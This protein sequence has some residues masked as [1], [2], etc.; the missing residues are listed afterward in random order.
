MSN[1]MRKSVTSEK[2]AASRYRSGS[3][4]QRLKLLSSAAHALAAS[5]AA[6]ALRL[7]SGHQRR[8]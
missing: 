6:R 7:S 8:E 2:S 4:L 3:L 5:C 1:A